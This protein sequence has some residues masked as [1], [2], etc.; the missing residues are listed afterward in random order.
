MGMGSG[1]EAIN[2]RTSRRHQASFTEFSLFWVHTCDRL[3]FPEVADCIF[4]QYLPT[5]MLFFQCNFDK[6]PIKRWGLSSLFLNLGGLVTVEKRCYL[7]SE[8]RP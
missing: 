7:A 8:A 3:Y 2:M 5:H 4:Q 6:T 1:E